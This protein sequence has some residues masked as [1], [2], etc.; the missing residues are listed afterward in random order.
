MIFVLLL[1]IVV[2]LFLVLV[3]PPSLSL[4]VPLFLLL[5]LCLALALAP[6][7]VPL[8]LPGEV[9]HPEQPAVRKAV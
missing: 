7:L 9:G 6:A 8:W 4:V 5:E 3:V 2:R 1:G